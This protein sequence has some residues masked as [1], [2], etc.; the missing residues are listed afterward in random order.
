MQRRAAA[1]ALAPLLLLTLALSHGLGGSAAHAPRQHDHA[2]LNVAFSFRAE[3]PVHGAR[4]PSPGADDDRNDE[5]PHHR[6]A[7]DGSGCE[8]L[9]AGGERTPPPDD[10]GS[11]T[12]SRAPAA[13]L[14]APLPPRGSGTRPRPPPR[15]TPTLLCVSRV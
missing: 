7:H 15:P 6:N 11:G 8:G 9:P 1:Y 4:E 13:E 3:P 10:S 14:L 12:T 2:S 5:R